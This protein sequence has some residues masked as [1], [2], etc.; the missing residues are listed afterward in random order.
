MNDIWEWNIGEKMTVENR[1]KYIRKNAPCA[2]LSTTYPAPILRVR[3]P[4][5]QLQKLLL[6]YLERMTAMC[7]CDRGETIDSKFFI[8]KKP[9][10]LVTSVSFPYFRT[11]YFNFVLWKR[12]C[13]VHQYKITSTDYL[14]IAHGI[15]FIRGRIIS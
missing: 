14:S 4:K 8:N 15:C 5:K 2:T 1:S 7:R 12:F 10:N 9:L 3:L 6:S 13:N 11:R